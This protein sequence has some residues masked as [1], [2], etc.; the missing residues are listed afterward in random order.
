MTPGA[1]VAAA[2]DLLDQV[3]SGADA[4]HC[5]TGWARRNRFAGS[6]DRAAIRDHVFGALRG[7]RSFAALGGGMSGRGLMIG[8]ER[9]AGRDP[10]ALFTGEGYAPAP[11][12]P[13]E[14]S[15]VAPPM[16][17][18]EALDMPDWLLP[19]L[20]RSL[21]DDLDPI[22]ALMR[23]R[24]PVFLRANLARGSRAEAQAAL[25]ADGVQTICNDLS[26]T[27]LAGHS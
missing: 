24:A 16:T 2:I 22:C 14:V 13:A 25:A 8:A 19:E 6:K 21:G 9:A 1:R 12:S 7:L 11:L 3:L 27:G 26:R 5:L 10:S 20:E 23:R 18:G 17:R 4:E 15:F